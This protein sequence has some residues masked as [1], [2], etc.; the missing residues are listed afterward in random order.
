M[1][2]GRQTS[3]G[4]LIFCGTCA[5]LLDS[6]G[7]QDHIVCQACGDDHE[8]A[9]FE[10]V[11]TVSCSQE[12]AFPSRLRNKRALVQGVG[13]VHRENARVDEP[14]PRCGAAEMTYQTIQMRSA[15]EGQTVFYECT[16]CGHGFSVNN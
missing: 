14:C 12:S 11:E 15:D 13:V 1:A 16:K 9:Q 7:D 10:G 3:F 6:P 4:S 2:S 8:G 5:N